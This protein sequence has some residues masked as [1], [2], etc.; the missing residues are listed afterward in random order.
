MLLIDPFTFPRSKCL[1]VRVIDG[2]TIA[3]NVI[4][5]R[6]GD[7]DILVKSTIRLIRIDAAERRTN[8]G[9][10]LKKFLTKLLESATMIEAQGIQKDLFG[11]VL[12]E[13]YV[14]SPLL[15]ETSLNLSDFF[16]TYDLVL[17]ADKRVPRSESRET[18]EVKNIQSM[19]TKYSM[20]I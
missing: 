19:F 5:H 15:G 9:Y 16:L 20:S 13:V 18:E 3:C 14:S 7:E 10:L 11:R 6:L 17:Q 8:A 2:D 1:D 4:H 12:C